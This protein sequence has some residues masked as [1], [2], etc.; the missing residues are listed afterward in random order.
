MSHRR[1]IVLKSDEDS[2]PDA[3]TIEASRLCKPASRMG[4]GERTHGNLAG[5][6]WWLD[7]SVYD[8]EIVID[9]T[10]EQILIGIRK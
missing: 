9:E 7:S 1:M 2:S 8:W 10:G 5:L 6:G 4:M 3:L